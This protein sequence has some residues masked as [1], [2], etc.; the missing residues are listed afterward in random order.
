[1]FLT[2]LPIGPVE[3]TGRLREL[4]IMQPMSVPVPPISSL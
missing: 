4:A 1:V 2:L 3:L